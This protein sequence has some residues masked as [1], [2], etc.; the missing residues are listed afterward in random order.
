MNRSRSPALIGLALM[1]AMI[2][3][4]I[5]GVAVSLDDPLPPLPATMTAR[6]ETRVV[7]RVLIVTTT[8]TR[9]PVPTPTPVPVGPCWWG[10]KD[11]E[12]CRWPE[13]TQVVPLPDCPP[14]TP[15]AGMVCVWH[16]PTIAS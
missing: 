1:A 8:P 16:Y 14:P 3:A 2:A 4:A 6:V 7:A 9:T 5:A 10:G 11:A 13:P 12:V 15:A